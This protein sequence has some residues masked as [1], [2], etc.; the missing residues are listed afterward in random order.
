MS[1]G[2]DCQQCY[3]NSWGWEHKK[4]C[5]LCEC[6]HNGAIGQTCDLYSGQCVCREGFTGRSC[7]KCSD[8][9]FGY[10]AC[11][12]CNCNRDGSVTVSTNVSEIIACDNGGQCPCKTLVV[13]KKCDTCHAST[14]GL[15][16]HNIDGCTHCFC[17]GRSHECEQ[18][19]LS[20]G[21]IR[22]AGVRSLNVEYQNEEYVSVDELSENRLTQ[23]D[24]EIT[25][26]NGLS[27]IPGTHGM[28]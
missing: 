15:S 8:G 21:Q 1:K 17:F 19:K 25:I 14:F 9:Y 6:D 4:G 11:D 24:A 18:S 5:K 20:W 2:T 3:P 22:M 12:R 26:L 27:V 23:Q 28:K 10:P 16:R 7:E 13:G